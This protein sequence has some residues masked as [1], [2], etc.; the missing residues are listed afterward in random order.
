[1]D[2]TKKQKIPTHLKHKPIIEVMDYSEIDGQ[3]AGKTDAKF[4]SVGVAQWNKGFKTELS[5]KVWRKTLKDGKERWSRQSEEL[6]LH[7]VIDLASLVCETKAYAAGD[8]LLPDDYF[9][10]KKVQASDELGDLDEILKNELNKNNE[11]LDKSLHRLAK[12]LKKIGY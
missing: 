10:V 12:A 4:L 1:M 3:F 8:E 6:P 11:H 2:N 9:K 7:R 5:A